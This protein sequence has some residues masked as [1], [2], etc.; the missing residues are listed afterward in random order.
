MLKKPVD[1]HIL[2]DRIVAELR[3]MSSILSSM[4]LAGF[5]A[6][7]QLCA[8]VG[9]CGER[10]TALGENSP[11]QLLGAID[12]RTFKG[13]DKSIGKIRHIQSSKRT[14]VMHSGAGGGNGIK[15]TSPRAANDSW[16]FD[17]GVLEPQ[18]WNCA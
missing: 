14:S 10:G 12:L 18:V 3:F 7:T 6:H 16:C 4:P 17:G 1:S 15:S 11:A 2:P 13:R 8:G 5:S 9:K